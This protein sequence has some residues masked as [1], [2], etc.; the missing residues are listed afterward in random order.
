MN[1]KQAQEIAEAVSNLDLDFVKDRLSEIAENTGKRHTWK[2]ESHLFVNWL[3]DISKPVPYTI[4]TKG[5]GKLPFYSFSVLPIVTCPGKGECENFCY[6]VKAWRYPIAFF[7]QIQNTIL[8]LTQSRQLVDAWHNLPTNIDFRLYV[9][10]DFDSIDTVNFWFGLCN[11]R[12]DIKVYGYSKSWAEILEF[13]GKYPENYKL[14]LSSGHSHSVKTRKQIKALP[15]VRGDFVT[16]PIE[17]SVVGKYGTPKYQQSLKQSAQAAGIEKYFACPG[18]CGNCTKKG[19]ACGS[20]T[21][22]SVPILIGIH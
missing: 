18:K 5:N 11:A 6:S 4:F 2:H 19:H 3:K 9:D 13:S 16:L 21:F 14:N 10:G 22:S 1:R 12:E 20:E 8:V 15:I 17:K 7:R